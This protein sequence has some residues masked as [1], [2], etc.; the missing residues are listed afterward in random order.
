MVLA[1]FE[2]IC[3]RCGRPFP[4][5]PDHLCGRCL[6]RSPAFDRARSCAVYARSAS[7]APLARA[8][9]GLKYLGDVSCA[10]PL[11]RILFERAP[12]DRTYDAV[13]PVPL[14][15]DRLR[16]RGFN[17]AIL[18]ARP[19]ARR[20]RAELRVDGLVRVRP[21]TPQIELGV[22]ERQSNIRGAFAVA[23]DWSP[24]D[25][26]LLL[27]DDVFTTGATVEECSRTLRR[28]GAASVDVLTLAR[29]L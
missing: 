19:L 22:R 9:H 16:W 21:T 2:A 11:T 10:R 18:L 29:A 25:L 7:D 3:P 28:A 14:H 23:R 6:A 5:R 17:Q 26:R 27:V 13:L 4:S 20:L 8:L 15:I 24:R 1:A 12:H